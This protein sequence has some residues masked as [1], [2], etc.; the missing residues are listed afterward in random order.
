MALAILDAEV[1]APVSL[2]SA[3]TRMDLDSADNA[4]NG[5]NPLTSTTTP[6]KEKAI[7]GHQVTSKSDTCHGDRQHFSTSATNLPN[8][9]QYKHERA[10]PDLSNGH[11]PAPCV[12]GA[13]INPTDDISQKASDI[14]NGSTLEKMQSSEANLGPH[15][16]IVVREWKLLWNTVTAMSPV[17]IDTDSLSV[18]KVTAV[19]K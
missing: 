2:Y 13:S 11:Q 18:A 14:A 4:E 10:D 19:S 15:A 12:I 16:S 5:H 7:S 8:E 6:L 17:H 1:N 3:T 9:A